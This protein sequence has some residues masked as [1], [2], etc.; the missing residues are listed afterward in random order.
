MPSGIGSDVAAGRR[1]ATGDLGIGTLRHQGVDA[2][3]G[4]EVG[5][6]LGQRVS[7]DGIG[8]T[9]DGIV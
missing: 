2:V 4:D 1:I 9:L 3:L 5:F 7:L 8:R 6:D